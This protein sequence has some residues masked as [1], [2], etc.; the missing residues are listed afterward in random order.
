LQHGNI[1]LTNLQSW[2]KINLEEADVVLHVD[3]Q[4]TTGI[5]EFSLFLL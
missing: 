5:I 2:E 3:I 4:I 1:I